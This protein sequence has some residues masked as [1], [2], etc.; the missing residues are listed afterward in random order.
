MYH[1]VLTPESLGAG[2]STAG[3][4]T[5]TNQPFTYTL[6]GTGGKRYNELYNNSIK[7]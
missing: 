5:K 2:V 6:Y 7:K 3:M 4:N 1:S